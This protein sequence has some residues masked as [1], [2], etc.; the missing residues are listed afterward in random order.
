MPV[1]NR[2]AD[3]KPEMAEWR[4]DIHAHPELAFEEHRTAKVVAAKL[5]EFGIEVHEGLAVTGVVGTLKGTG[6]GPAIAIRADM[7]A[8][9]LQETTGLDYQSTHDGKM[10]ACG[11][12]GHT[13][14]LLGAARYLAETRNFSGTVHFIFQPAEEGAGGAKVMM[15]EGLFEKFP[16]Q[17]VYGLHNWPGLP[18]GQFSVRSGPVMAAADFFEITITGNG[19]HGAMPHLGHDPVIAASQI[20]TAVQTIVS[21]NVDPLE[22]GVISVTKI[23]GG[24]A[25]NVIPE[26]VELAGTARAFK[27][28]VRDQIENGLNRIATNVAA[29]HNCVA[30]V[31]YTRNYP[32]T[33]N[34]VGETELAAAAA[35]AVVGAENVRRDLAPC[36]GSEDFAF[37][38]E[39]NPGCYVWMGNGHGEGG[40]FLHNPGYD[41]N[42]ETL[43]VGASYWAKLIENLLPKAA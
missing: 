28:D 21:R 37:M 23:H 9:A 42:D 30:D 12:D 14:M 40:C 39:E 11:H 26:K 38:L 33:V 17:A 13:T 32:A 27:S 35:A 3:M 6:D 2:I 8:L 29:A 1:N 18:T 34:S 41:F 10:H 31:N 7:D 43:P 16:V 25:M 5:K 19:G 20:V 22:A 4:Q 24:D 15:D 36:M